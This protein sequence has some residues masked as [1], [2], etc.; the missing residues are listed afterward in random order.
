MSANNSKVLFFLAGVN[1][2]AAE[3]AA[4]ARLETVFRNVKVRSGADANLTKYGSGQLESF[5][6]LAGAGIPT[7]YSAVEGAV[8]LTVPVATIPDD[9]KVYPATLSVD[10]SDADVQTPAAVKAEIVNGLAKLTNLTGDASVGWTSSD[11]T[12]ATVHATTGKITA[13][14]AGTT[15]IT[16]TLTIGSVTKTA[17]MALTV[18]E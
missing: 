9:F 7:A 8:T 2:T 3:V 15:T 1:A 14:A 6:F 16:A 4:I 18:V 17:A 11:E 10:A 13:V 12:K 5:D